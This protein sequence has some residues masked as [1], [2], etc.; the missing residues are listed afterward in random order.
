MASEVG[1]GNGMDTKCN[2]SARERSASA[3]VRAEEKYSE[4]IC[5]VELITKKVLQYRDSARKPAHFTQLL[6]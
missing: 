2:P 5:G 4:S 6:T 1:P 3:A